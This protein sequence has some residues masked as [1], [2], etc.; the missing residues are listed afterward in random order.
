MT[1]ECVVYSICWCTLAHLQLTF[2]LASSCVVRDEFLNLYQI[3]STLA[4]TTS[5]LASYYSSCSSIG[6]HDSSVSINCVF[7]LSALFC[8]SVLLLSDELTSVKWGRTHS[9]KSAYVP[10]HTCVHLGEENT[11][12][13]REIEVARPWCAKQTIIIQVLF[14]TMI[15]SNAIETTPYYI[16]E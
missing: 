11:Y 4:T 1:N 16:R 12:H 15:I 9:L 10:L 14:L 7:L 3:V 5:W 13:Q 2:A 6:E 8:L